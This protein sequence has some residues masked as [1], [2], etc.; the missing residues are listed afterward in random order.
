M[1]IEEIE[2]Q[3]ATNKENLRN[4]KLLSV[5]TIHLLPNRH[6]EYSDIIND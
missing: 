5:F 2:L 1:R 3:I 4:T 6:L